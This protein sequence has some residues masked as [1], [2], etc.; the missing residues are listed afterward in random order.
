M[1]V[2]SVY[3]SALFS[4]NVCMYDSV[5]A[6]IHIIYICFCSVLC[7]RLRVCLLA[8]FCFVLSICLYVCFC[9]VLRVCLCSVLC[10]RLR[11]C[12]GGGSGLLL[13]GAGV[14][15]FLLKQF[16]YGSARK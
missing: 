3:A 10:V 1:C 6:C 9:F 16:A 13:C 4:V 8:C 15:F 11:V 2:E 7:V 14:L 5:D 12:W